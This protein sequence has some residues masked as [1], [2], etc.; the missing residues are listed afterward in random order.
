MWR[1]HNAR[2]EI[3]WHGYLRAKDPSAARALFGRMEALLQRA[4]EELS[5]ERYWKDAALFEARL[6]TPLQATTLDAAILEVMVAVGPL[7]A[8]GFG[9][10]QTFSDG[11]GSF[12]GMLS[13]SGGDRIAVPGI[14]LLM[15]EVKG[16]FAA[17]GPFLRSES[18]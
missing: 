15:F 1:W 11:S 12:E 9:V 16:P 7:G 3:S 18:S 14:E 10:P 2:V 5:C 4:T 13:H 6:C 8:W 17:D